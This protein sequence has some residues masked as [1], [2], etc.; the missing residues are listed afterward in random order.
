MYV[1]VQLIPGSP[2]L[3]THGLA[4]LQR[5]LLLLNKSFGPESG[6]YPEL[7]TTLD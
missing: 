6:V 4:T 5:Q 3:S 7:A 2:I 1:I